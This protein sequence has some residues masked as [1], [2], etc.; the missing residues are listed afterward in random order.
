MTIPAGSATASQVD[1]IGV[2][3][4]PPMFSPEL[5]AILIGYYRRDVVPLTAPFINLPR[6][7]RTKPLTIFTSLATATGA[8]DRMKS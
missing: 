2:T 5:A 7:F 3:A 1:S 6:D 4:G 8:G